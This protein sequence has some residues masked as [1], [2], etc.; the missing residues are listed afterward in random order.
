MIKEV[1]DVMRD[2][3]NS[4]MTILIVTHEIKFCK[5]VSTRVLFMDKGEIIEDTNPLNYLI[6]QKMKS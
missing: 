3:A 4:G 1:L 2:L 5:N 6:I